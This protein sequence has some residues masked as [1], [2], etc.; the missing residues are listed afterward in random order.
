[1]TAGS[2]A[3]A[4]RLHAGEIVVDETR[5]RSLLATQFPQWAGLDIR[6]V[7][8]TGTDSVIYRLGDDLAARFP[9]IEWAVGQIEKEWTWLPRLSQALP[10]RV[11]DMV[12]LGEPAGGYPWPWLVYRWLDGDSLLDAPPV[13]ATALTSDIAEF[14]TTLQ[15]VA[16]SAA[17]ESAYRGG[18]LQPHDCDLRAALQT[19]A[20]EID[21][22]RAVA[23][24]EDAL[25]APPWHR[26]PVW[27]HGDMLPG[28]LILRD[29]RLTGVIDWGAAGIGD[30]ACDL[31]I[32]WALD[33]PSR[34]VLLDTLDVDEATWRRA[35]GW[36]LYQAA[37]FIPY[38]RHTIPR[39]VEAARRRLAALLE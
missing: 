3:A 17:P 25:A 32:A 18:P 29:G 20:A 9:R 27:V 30:P 24:W 23:V 4:T 15:G 16:A 12:A 2:T 1:M 8:S 21:H 26:P 6:L 38:Y 7:P 14:L 22:D 35:A 19:L 13:A 37:L 39:G 36:T 11:P 28:N 33:A 5:A 31:M 10:A 34:N